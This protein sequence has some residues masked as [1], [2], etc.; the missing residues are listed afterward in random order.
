MKTAVRITSHPHNVGGELKNTT[1]ISKICL[2]K[3]MTF[4]FPE[5]GFLLT[6]FNSL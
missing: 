2:A 4:A 3:Q 6:V 1:V 5:S